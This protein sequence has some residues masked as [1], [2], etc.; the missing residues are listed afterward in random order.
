MYKGTKPTQ[1]RLQVVEEA[2]D[3][4]TYSFSGTALVPR[5][6][7]FPSGLGAKTIMCIMAGLVARHSLFPTRRLDSSPVRENERASGNETTPWQ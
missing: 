4:S 2:N 5:P 6:F 3:D 1:Q 7:S